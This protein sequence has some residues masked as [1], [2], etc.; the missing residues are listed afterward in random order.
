MKKIVMKSNGP[1]TKKRK[2][3]APAEK[4]VKAPKKKQKASLKKP[5]RVVKTVK[6]S[7][8]K[9]PKKKKAKK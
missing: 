3:K 1:A 6:A 7:G 9:G 5:P 2:I 4:K 8:S